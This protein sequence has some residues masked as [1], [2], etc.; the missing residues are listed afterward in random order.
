MLL[1]Q[2]LIGTANGHAGL[3]D[4]PEDVR[5]ALPETEIEQQLLLAAGMLALYR[6]A[7]RRPSQQSLAPP[8]PKDEARAPSPQVQTILDEC[9]QGEWERW[10]PRVAERLARH[11]Y[12]VK[13]E[14]LVGVLNAVKAQDAARWRPLLGARGR[15]LA[16]QNPAWS[17]A[18]ADAA[19][20]DLSQQW[21][22]GN[23]PQRVAALRVQRAENATLG[24]EWL[25]AVWKGEKA[26][27]RQALLEALGVGLNLDDQPFLNGGL[28]DRSQAVRS[29]A[30]ALL[31]MLPQSDLARRLAGRAQGW[32]TFQPAQ[33]ALGKMASKLISGSDGT[34]HIEPAANWDKSWARD[35]FE[36]I[37]PQGE[38]AR[39]FWLRQ[40]VAHV[41][42]AQWRAHTGLAP[43][44]FI[45]AAL[46]TDWAQAM[47]GGLAIAVRRFRDADW[48]L[49]LYCGLTA[50]AEKWLHANDLLPLIPPA[51]REALCA[52]R[53]VAG[54]PEAAL[55]LAACDHPWSEA[56]SAAVMRATRDA[57]HAARSSA[58]AGNQ[59]A[60]TEE[61][62]LNL[63]PAGLAAL[64]APWQETVSAL[65]AHTDDWRARNAASQFRRQLQLI[66]RRMQFDK[67]VAP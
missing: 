56:L 58:D 20:P 8:A 14:K 30:A 11:G 7:G 41:P 38:G 10:W 61:A 52:E 9:L 39:S 4:L 46:A 50:K 55:A 67:E 60:L 12:T 53:V 21:L 18:L 27:A 51:Q 35:G 26:D 23:L 59:L 33:G 29:T 5:S 34:L 17:W 31:V 66:E 48:A 37:P 47:L 25:E 64:L 2:A 45:K 24:R 49:A 1:Q 42:P 65:E 62:A 6:E 44:A 3:P 57:L 19:A 32:V 22:E 28:G 13:I 63:A 43:E 16:A 36:E 54:H 15:W 40:L